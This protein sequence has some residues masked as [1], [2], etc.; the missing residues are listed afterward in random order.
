MAAVAY[1]SSKA[2]KDF[3]K[4]Q[5]EMEKKE[6][7]E[8]P[9]E[10]VKEIHDIYHRKGFR[11]SFLD[12]IVKKITSNKRLWVS[13]MLTE[14]LHLFPKQFGKPLKDSVVVGGSAIVGSIIPIL[15]FFFLGVK[16]AII[17]SLI[18]SLIVLF[19]T[20]AIK[21]K[22]TIGNWLKSG[23][24]MAAIGMGAAVIGFLVGWLFNKL[25]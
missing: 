9:K 10:E 1:T 20:G 19:V 18:V 3:Y 11:G 6:I 16:S 15:P 2:A 13:T 23:I 17:C 8:I 7:K 4:S 25:Y 14:E 22:V 12:K 21:A 5:V 24:E